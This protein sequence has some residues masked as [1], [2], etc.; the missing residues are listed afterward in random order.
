MRVV[1]ASTAIICGLHF[2]HGGAANRH[3][4]PDIR[5]PKHFSG[6]RERP[7]L[8]WWGSLWAGRMTMAVPGTD[9]TSLDMARRSLAECTLFRG[10]S[11]DEKDALAA[12]A[13]L[14]RFEA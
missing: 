7:S 11:D 3:S 10:L 6:P 13:R 12:R 1:P 2:G 8:R 9:R 5:E 4:H 14:R